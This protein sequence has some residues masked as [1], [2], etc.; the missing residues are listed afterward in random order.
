MLGGAWPDLDSVSEVGAGRVV[1]TRSTCMAEEFFE[2]HFPIQPIVPAVMLLSWLEH[3]AGV[4]VGH[5]TGG[6][7][8]AVLV[9]CRKVTCLSMAR[10]GDVLRISLG[11][12]QAEDWSGRYEQGISYPISGHVECGEVRILR[13]SGRMACVPLNETLRR[14]GPTAA[15][16]G[17]RDPV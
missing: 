13:V 1:A 16:L 2:Y 8:G 7:L 11:L 17:L 12:D 4:M 9:E 3:A 14:W 6:C 15:A 10:P 5:A